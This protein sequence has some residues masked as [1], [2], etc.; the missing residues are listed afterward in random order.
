MPLATTDK[1]S[2]FA[3]GAVSTAR[4]I[5]Y[6]TLAMIVMVIDHRGSYLER[7]RLFASTIVEPIYRAAAL[8]SDVAR[9]GSL[10]IA[11]QS[12][13]VDENRSLRE[14]LLLAQVRLN[15]MSALSA[16]NDRLKKLLDVQK[17]LGLGVQLARL[18]DIDL[19]PFRHR[20][21][22]DAGSAQSI[23]VGQ[24]VLDAHGVMG[25][26]VEV[27]PNTS[28]A[29]LVTDPTHAIPVMIERTG[30]RTIAY[31]TGSIDRLQLPNIPI[32]ADI[33]VGD[34][35]V[36]SGLGGRFPAGFPVGEI[37]EI[38]NDE[39]GM[40]AAA[41]ARPAAAL[42]R[43]GEVLLLQDLPQPV[44][45]PAPLDAASP[46]ADRDPDTSGHP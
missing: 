35:L 25:Q 41:I 34:A 24:P 11:T 26:I 22:L 5:A 45:P 1:V 7:L 20:I 31:G 42:D 28:V 2:L 8:P 33:K 13:L 16:Q 21:V 15:R 14:A 30:L 9:A 46:D 29:M 36:T 39:S 4:L 43:S 23:S 12:H 6:L 38:S 37:L 32:S 3:E 10:A 27:L 44:G 18:I 40:F 19:D 17:D